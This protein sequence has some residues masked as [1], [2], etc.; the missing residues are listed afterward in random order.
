ME[1][2][3]NLDPQLEYL[4]QTA[5]SESTY[6][7]TFPEE[8]KFLSSR[9]IDLDMIESIREPGIRALSRA[10]VMKYLEDGKYEVQWTTNEVRRL[11]VHCE[12]AQKLISQGLRRSFVY[13]AT[14]RE[15]KVKHALVPIVGADEEVLRC[16][17][18]VESD[19]EMLDDEEYAERRAR[20]RT[21]EPGEMSR[22]D[23]DY[24]FSEE[25]DVKADSQ[26]S[27]ESQGSQ[28]SQA[29]QELGMSDD[30]DEEKENTNGESVVTSKEERSDSVVPAMS[31]GGL[32]VRYVSPDL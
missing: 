27:Q 5:S 31:W 6:C 17:S 29:S 2:K 1:L 8:S 28:E 11:E 10:E 12:V 9:K 14:P 30:E 7:L 15:G 3:L 13:R 24:Q 32:R 19:E 21:P 18:M 25:G 20:S 4:I 16:G 23:D 22:Y 26:E